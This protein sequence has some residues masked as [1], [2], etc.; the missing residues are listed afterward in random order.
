MLTI[1][2]A[3][4][5]IVEQGALYIQDELWGAYLAVSIKSV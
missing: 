1:K 3:L 2:M 4:Q 5:N